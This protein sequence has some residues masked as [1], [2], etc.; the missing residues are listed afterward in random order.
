MN[1]N[2]PRSRVSELPRSVKER[3]K[4]LEDVTKE[5]LSTGISNNRDFASFYVHRK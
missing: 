3:D 4:S 1:A 5:K 2:C